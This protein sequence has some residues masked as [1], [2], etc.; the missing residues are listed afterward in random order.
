MRLLITTAAAALLM[1]GQ[2]FAQDDDST[3]REPGDASFNPAADFSEYDDDG[4][5]MVSQDEFMAGMED[6][7]MS[8]DEMTSM[9][10][11]MDQD[12]DEMIS[13]EEMSAYDGGGMGSGDDTPG[14]GADD[15]SGDT[16]SETTD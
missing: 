12:G 10:G 1:T 3:S 9:F 5:G 6:Q 15:T 8:E 7:D 13:E 16:E 14:M 2:A 4:D 11:E